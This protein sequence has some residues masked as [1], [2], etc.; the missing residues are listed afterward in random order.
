MLART[1]RPAHQPR[2]AVMPRTDHHRIHLDIGEHRVR[3][4]GGL[5]EAELA[6][7]M[8]AADAAAR[9]HRLQPCT[10]RL[11]RRDQY[12]RG[13]V[14]GADEAHRRRASSSHARPRAPS[15][16]IIRIRPIARR[17]KLHAALQ[18]FGI[19]FFIRRRV[20]QQYAQRRSRSAYERIGLLRVT[21]GEAMR[22]QRPHV[23][24]PVG[25]H[26]EHRLEVALLGPAH[27]AHRI[28]ETLFLVVRVVAPRPIGAGH[29]KREFL[30]V[31]VRPRQLKTGYTHQHDAP[32]LAA[33]QRR[34]VHRL[35]ALGRGR[36]QHRIYAAA[37]RKRIRRSH[38]IFARGKVHHLGA[39]LPCQRQLIRVVIDAQH[40]AAVCAQKLHRQQPDQSQSRDHHGLAQRRLRQAYPLQRNRA[41]HRKG[42]LLVRHAIRHAGAQI[43]WHANHFGVLAVG[44]HAVANGEPWRT[45]FHLHRHADIAIAQRQRLVELV[46]HRLNSR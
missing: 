1:Q 18:H 10:G 39:E 31:E 21:D 30:L 41:E 14:A 28:V 6:P 34:L 16:G 20:L 25:H 3:I 42:C 45:G 11:E 40:A 13:I 27:E 4:G 8:H 43:R 46:A 44:G 19:R 35:A 9:R 15:P 22:D 29:L 33:H 26:V 38:R 37:A 32:A 17:T 24:P 12:C 2:V 5:L 36:D 7:G 23:Q